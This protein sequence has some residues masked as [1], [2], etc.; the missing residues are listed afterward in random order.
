[1][2]DFL[3][4]INVFYQYVYY[5]EMKNNTIFTLGIQK[6]RR[7]TNI[8]AVIFLNN[9]NQPYLLHYIICLEWFLLKLYHLNAGDVINV[10]LKIKVPQVT[11][12]FTFYCSRF[13]SFFT[14]M[15]RGSKFR[16]V[17][18]AVS[19][20]SQNIQLL[21]PKMIGMHMRSSIEVLSTVRSSENLNGT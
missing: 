21:K 3:L 9:I 6:M 11:G 10:L 12:L 17:M 16:K 15:S 2:P 18:A 14:V 13:K 20:I 7:K 8:Q 4:F 1:M 19:S 5:F